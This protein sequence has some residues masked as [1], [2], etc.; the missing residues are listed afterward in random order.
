MPIDHIAPPLSLVI[1]IL[2][3]IP[4]ASKTLWNYWKRPKL[5]LDVSHIHIDFVNSSNQIERPNFVAI[6][7]ENPQ[8]KELHIDLNKVNINGASLA[9]IIQQNNYFSR[10]LDATKSEYKLTTQNS[11]LNLFRENWTQSKLFKISA[12][13]KL[14]LPLYPQGM[15]DSLYFKELKDANIFRPKKKIV[16]S[17]T[18]NSG[19]YYYA[20]DRYALL[21]AIV[22]N[23]VHS[24]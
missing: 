9:Y 15:D 17:M 21:K 14:E 1:S 23:L 11:L 20:V 8:A 4:N 5:K 2:K 10:T 12:H 22:N 7:L 24:S 3:I 19:N 16:L 6:V 18:I 13:E